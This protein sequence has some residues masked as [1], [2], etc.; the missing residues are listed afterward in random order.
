MQIE[1][2]INEVDLLL[3]IV[4]GKVGLAYEDIVFRD[5]LKKISN[6]VSSD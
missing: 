3:F 4:D 1:M 5:M 2:E 6:K